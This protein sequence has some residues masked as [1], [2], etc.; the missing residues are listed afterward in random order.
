[1]LISKFVPNFEFYR[2]EF[3]I[4]ARAARSK[5]DP[6]NVS[7]NNR[8]FFFILT[9]PDLGLAK[10]YAKNAIW[11]TSQLIEKTMSDFGS[12]ILFVRLRIGRR[13]SE[14]LNI[15]FNYIPIKLNFKKN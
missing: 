10:K 6:I 7:A 4:S 8:F 12:N 15:L 5:Y 1:M 9:S 14:R 11:F 2:L 13:I 3:F